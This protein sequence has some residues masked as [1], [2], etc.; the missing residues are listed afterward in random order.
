[1]IQI[2]KYNNINVEGVNILIKPSK[3]YELSHK[4][5]R[6]YAEN[7]IALRMWPLYTI[8]ED[9]INRICI[10]EDFSSDI[11]LAI[12]MADSIDIL[13]DIL[14]KSKGQNV[15]IFISECEGINYSKLVNIL[16]ESS[17]QVNLAILV[18]EEYL[19]ICKDRYIESTIPANKLKKKGYKGYDTIDE[20][21]VHKDLVD[22]LQNR[23]F[24]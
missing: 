2:N 8:A 6:G 21:L 24:R 18:N 19:S 5:P 4:K 12:V 22:I 13:K 20:F 1:M 23:K 7:F 10:D 14:D 17:L 3:D 9:N 11:K 16:E 15:N